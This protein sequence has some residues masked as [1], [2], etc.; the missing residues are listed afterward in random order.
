[1]TVSGFKLIASCILSGLLLNA[2]GKQ[3]SVEQHIIAN[4]EHM[5]AAAE[6]GRHLDFMGYVA[7]NFG[8]QYGSMDRREFHRF[9]IFQINEN[10]RLH[11][12]F[13]P[14]LVRQDPQDNG[15]EISAASAQFRLLVTGGGGL[16]PERG[17]LFEVK[18]NWIL[19]SGDWLLL[20]ADWETVR[21]PE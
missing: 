7:K 11:A 9:M 14:I 21:M 15:N 5:E 4:L 2:C 10:R 1:M 18:T 16:L 6:D 12:T 20:S 17:Q 3:F 19:E 8:G 13:F